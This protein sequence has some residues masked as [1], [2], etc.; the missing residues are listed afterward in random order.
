M[1]AST[2]GQQQEPPPQHTEQ[3][4]ARRSSG[5]GATSSTGGAA[6]TAADSLL[7][8]IYGATLTEEQ[9]QQQAAAAQE[10]AQKHAAAT[11]VRAAAAEAA[12]AT[13]AW[14]D[15][16]GVRLACYTAERGLMDVHQLVT[17][18]V[19]V[20]SSKSNSSSSHKL[21][22]TALMLAA[23]AVEQV[24]SCQAL[25][26]NF[27]SCLVTLLT[28]LDA[29]DPQQGM[30][31][32][33]STKQ[34]VTLTADNR[35]PAKGDA[36]SGGPGAAATTTTNSSSTAT[37]LRLLARQTLEKVLLLAPAN[38]TSL[39]C[40]SQL[41]KVLLGTAAGHAMLFEHTQCSSACHPAAAGSSGSNGGG[42]SG[43]SVL[44]QGHSAADANAGVAGSLQSVLS[45]ARQMASAVSPR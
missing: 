41:C 15:Q 31:N 17:W 2:P 6:V 10:A 36:T 18:V 29:S 32:P 4:S 44:G 24:C 39:D 25:V 35:S 27:C 5:V 37:K 30:T 34:P 1:N 43:S 14:Q 7:G 42:G 40:L 33:D 12:A 26:A 11:A 22:E 9:Q 13:A 21:R 28:H 19:K 20:L 45:M 23:A 16:Q 38:L 8:S 3:Y